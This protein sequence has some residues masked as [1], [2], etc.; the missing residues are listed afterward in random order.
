MKIT[1]VGAGAIGGYFAARLAHSGQEVSIL[2]RGKTLENI[3][4]HGI[5]LDSEGTH[6]AERVKA[7]DRAADLGPQDVVIITVK[8]PALPAA[9]QSIASLLGAQTS[10]V[11]AVNG[12]PWWYFLNAGGK[13]AGHRL[14]SVDPEGATEA[15]I[16]AARVVGCVVFP[17][18][19]SIEPG[20]VKHASGNR[21]VFGEP[22]GDGTGGTSERVT[23]IAEAFKA[24]GFGAESSANIRREIWLKLLGN[25]CFN[26]VSALMGCTTDRM[27]DDPRLHALFVGVMTEALA[28]GTALGIPVDIKPAER[29]A[30]TRKLGA[31]KTSMLQD[32]EA[33]RPLEVEG[34]VGAAVEAA[35]AIG[36]PAPLLSAVYALVR[37]RADVLGLLP[38]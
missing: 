29:I 27:I 5:R 26:P 9:A 31:V 4:D 14:H 38:A 32:V 8:A 20:Y 15:A 10:V 36:H 19:S 11:P 24:A 37:R 2:A 12:I 3:R 35:E 18:C 33:G 23:Q 21:V 25:L 13:L 30:I 17:A 22:G 1:I 6:F 34:I 7:S 16:A 28:L